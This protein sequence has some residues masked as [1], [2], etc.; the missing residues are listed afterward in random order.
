MS[1]IK[2]TIRDK[3]A[4][5]N[6][7]VYVCGNSDYTIAFDFDPEWDAYETKTARFVYGEKYTDVVFSGNTCQVP[8]LT[9]LYGFKVGVFAGDLHTT[10]PA[11]V[12]AKKSILCS[13]GAP[14]DPAPDVYNQIMEKLNSGGSGG[15]VPSDW[16][17]A[18]GEPGHV[19]NRTHYV[20]G[21]MEVLFEGE[22]LPLPTGGSAP[23]SVD[24]NFVAGKV[25]TVTIND[26]SYVATAWLDATYNIAL[27]GATYDSAT[28]VYDFSEFPFS[29][30]VNSGNLG[31]SLEN[32]PV[33]TQTLKI[34]EGAIHK[35]PGKFIP[36]QN[37][38]ASEG[39]DGYIEG[40]THYSKIEEEVRGEVAFELTDVN[41]S[42]KVGSFELVAGQEYKVIFDGDIYRLTAF[43]VE[44]MDETALGGPYDSYEGS[45][46]L[47]EVPFALFSSVGGGK[48]GIWCATTGGHSVTVSIETETLKRLD[49]K[50]MPLLTSPNGTKYLLTVSDNGTLTATPTA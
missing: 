13:E 32:N 11:K 48:T 5:A 18:E 21:S 26:V 49:E 46:D 2:I 30:V 10:T 41:R 17:A 14:A 27:V 15:G 25:Y 36:S 29:V 31:V 43:Y 22:F 39:E 38:N 40:R 12:A 9:N 8:V 24:F 16:N 3:V 34:V 37:W 35:L 50:F 19:L 1:E 47:S 4:I 44:D 42:R 23:I 6:G 7:V 33:G 28:Y 20:E 45:Y